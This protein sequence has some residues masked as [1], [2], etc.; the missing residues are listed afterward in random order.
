VRPGAVVEA[1]RARLLELGR[2]PGA[3]IVCA[4]F[5]LLVIS[6]GEVASASRVQ[7]VRQASSWM[8][9]A[10]SAL[11]FV[12]AVLIPVS[13][14]AP[15]TRLAESRIMGRA[16]ANLAHGVAALLFLTFLSGLLALAGWIW[17]AATFPVVDGATRGPVV[18]DVRFRSAEA[19][20]L[21][22]GTS[23]S[24]PPIPLG[25]A[26]ST[27]VVDLAPS[28]RFAAREAESAPAD[29][30]RGPVLELSWNLGDKART[31]RIDLAARGAGPMTEI[32]ELPEAG[33][34]AGTMTLTLRLAGPGGVAAFESGAVA[35]LGA[36]R[37]LLPTLLR[38]FLIVG[39]LA[40]V[41]AAV[42]QWFSNFVGPMIAVAAVATLAM[43]AAAVA[44]ANPARPEG[45]AAL[46]APADAASE[47]LRGHALAWTDVRKAA[48]A[49]LLA[50]LGG[51]LAAVRGPEQRES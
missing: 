15:R 26:R 47:I 2:G 4:A 41:A 24:S 46:V 20:L 14:G 33:A 23:W 5:V 7:Q 31:R 3:V 19:F 30:R 29:G 40:A 32:L 37:A 22:G 36:P 21:A 48:T 50:V 11:L 6:V 39:C 17:L 12:S 35:V 8:L 42:S 34:R 45:L 49:G 43:V 25:E 51:S 27:V 38:S 9:S 10:A 13:G 18:R 28:L 16:G 1:A 44:A